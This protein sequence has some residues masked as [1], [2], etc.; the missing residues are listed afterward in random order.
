MSISSSLNLWIWYL[1]WQWGSQI[2]HSTG[3][4]WSA[5]FK[6][7]RLSALDYLGRPIVITGRKNR[8]MAAPEGFGPMMEAL[9][10][11]EESVSQGMWMGL[12]LERQRS[13]FPLELLERSVPCCH[14]NFC[15]MTSMLDFT[16]LELLKWWFVLF[17]ANFLIICYGNIRKPKYLP[18]IPNSPTWIRISPLGYDSPIQSSFQSPMPTYIYSHVLW[19]VSPGAFEG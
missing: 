5:I 3:A 18:C 6:K 15:S 8:K 11:E 19:K 14:L 10:M 17:E 1:I 4:C 12:K 7:G 2:T 16:F 13:S 9:K